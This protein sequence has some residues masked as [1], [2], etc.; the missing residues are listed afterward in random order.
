M[1]E[2]I[3]AQKEQQFSKSQLTDPKETH[4][5]NWDDKALKI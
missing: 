1:L 4:T 2:A 5:G 3:H